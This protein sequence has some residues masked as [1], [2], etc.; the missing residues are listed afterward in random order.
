ME[1]LYTEYTEPPMLKRIAITVYEIGLEK[2][3]F[4]SA[5]EKSRKP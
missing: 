3:F 1:G 5:A 2:A 4:Y